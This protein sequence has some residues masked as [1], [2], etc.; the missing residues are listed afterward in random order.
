LGLSWL[1]ALHAHVCVQMDAC[2][3]STIPVI[4]L[5]R[6]LSSERPSLVFDLDTL[7][8]YPCD[9]LRY[10]KE[11]LR[12]EDSLRPRFRQMLRVVSAQEFVTHF[13]SDRS[14]MLNEQ[15]AWLAPPPSYSCIQTKDCPMNLM[16]FVSM[17]PDS[18]PY[19]KSQILSVEQFVQFLRFT[20][21][22][23]TAST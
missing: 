22:G 5:A 9:A 18:L 20:P 1:A 21:G 19:V 2:T 13:A 4:F 3:R 11:A 10:V 14:H 6:S 12:P 7:L 8:P 15:G 17:H 16:D 23:A